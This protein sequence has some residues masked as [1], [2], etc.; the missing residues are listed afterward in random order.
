VT[1][2]NQE[3]IAQRLQFHKLEE[4]LAAIG[5]GDISEHQI[6]HAVQEEVQPKVDEV[7]KPLVAK[8]AAIQSSPGGILVEGVGNL[9]TKLALCCKPAP[10]DSIVGY[11]TRDRGVTIHR[12]DCAGI[13][14]LPEGRHDRILSAQWGG[15]KGETFTVDIGLE[16]YDRQGLLR[17]ISDLFVREKVNVTRVNTLSKNNIAMMQF[18]IEITNLEQLSS[19]LALINQV[20]NVISAKRHV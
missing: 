13:L 5:R 7:A 18:S 3:K 11:V 2:I 4:L 14:R 8:P 16:A 19:L 9:L 10:P 12:R 15:E 1:A 6:A 17:D 20:D